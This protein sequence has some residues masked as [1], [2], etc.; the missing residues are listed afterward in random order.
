MRLNS[1]LAGLAA[2]ACMAFA[3]T[4]ADAQ[5][6]LRFADFGAARGLR[7]DQMQW[8]SDEL[9]KRTEG[10]VSV[11]YHYGGSLLPAREIV[12]GISNGVADMG[13][14][15]AVYNPRELNPF[16][17]GD[18]PIRV[19]DNWSASRAMLTLANEDGSAIK[20]AFDALNMELIAVFPVG[21]TQLVCSKAGIKGVDDLAGKR[22]LTFGGLT[23]Q[24]ERVG[25]KPQALT[26]PEAFQGLSSGLL[27]CTIVYSYAVPAY[28]FHEIADQY[29]RINFISPVAMGSAINKDSLARLSEQDQATVRELGVELTDRLVNAVATAGEEVAAQLKAGIDGRVLEV[30]E[31]TEEDSKKLWGAG[32]PDIQKWIDESAGMGFDGAVLRDR[33]LALVAQFDKERDEKGYPWKR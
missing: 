14:A 16:L 9:K 10:R 11:E 1:T 13:T 33:Y 6:V 17:V 20:K 2:A 31:F 7:A 19:A 25:A 28:R 29:V 8:F 24:F 30:V 12:P 32:E 18:V 26:M 27:D 23:A 4:V 5:T 22:I 21:P 15:A 3:A